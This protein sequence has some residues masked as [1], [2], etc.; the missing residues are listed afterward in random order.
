MG[1]IPTPEAHAKAMR[2]ASGEP[3]PSQPS[4]SR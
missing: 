3:D 1:T 2:V 4:L